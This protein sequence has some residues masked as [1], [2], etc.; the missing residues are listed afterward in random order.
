[1]SNDSHNFYERGRYKMIFTDERVLGR[2]L[3]VVENAI[4]EDELV[5]NEWQTKE[6][7]YKSPGEYEDSG[8]WELINLG[9]RWTCSDG[10][11]RW[12]YRIVEV[13]EKFAGKN[14]VLDLEFGGEGLVKING[15][16]QS[17]LTSYLD[18]NEATRTRVVL[19]HVPAAGEKFEVEVEAGLNYMEF[20]HY[21]NQGW[22]SIEY[23]FR[24]AT[25]AAVDYE[26]EQYYFDI[27]TAFDAMLA[28]KSPIQKLTTA[29]VKLPF[30]MTRILESFTKDSYIH[31]KLQDAVLHSLTR[32]DADFGRDAVAKSVP[33]ASEIL[34][35]K[36]SEI[37]H[38]PHAL[39][40]FVGQAHIDTAWL[41]PIKETV[42]KCG[43]TMA[44]VLDLMDR[45]ED[46]I[47]SFSQPQLFEYTKKYYP[48]LYDRIKEKVESGQFELVGNTWVEMDTNVPSG[49]SLV[50]QLLYGRAFFQSEFGKSSRVFWMPDVFGYSWALPQI[51]KRSGMDYFF[52]SKLIGNDTN[53]FPHSLF[54]WQ[55]ID[56]TQLLSYVQRLN[57]N[58]KYTPETVE[59]IYN[60]F[61]QKHLTDDLLMTF[62]YGDGGGGPNYQ[63]LETSHRL[64]SFPGLQKTELNT[65]VS[66]FDSV[67]S[68]ADKLPVWNNEMYYEFHR[69]TYTSQARTKKHNREAE[70]GMRQAEML[71]AIAKDRYETDYPYEDILEAYRLILTNQFHD[72]IPGSSIQSVYVDCEKDYK[73]IFSIIRKIEA[74]SI[75][76]LSSISESNCVTVFNS[77]SWDRVDYVRVPLADNLNKLSVVDKDGNHVPSVY[78][79][80]H[81]EFE[82]WAPALGSAAYQLVENAPA[83]VKAISVSKDK[84]ENDFYEILLDEN[85]NLTSIYDKTSNCEV[86]EQGKISNQLLIFEDKP[87]CETAWNIDL[88]Y[89]NKYWDLVEGTVQVI[90]QS[91][92]KGVVRVTKKFNL[93]T[94]I[95]DIV[96]YRSIPRID[97]RTRVD[98]NETEKML[99][100]AFHVNV[101]SSKAVYEIQ[102]GAIERP[103]HWNTSYDK[104][105][106]E[107]CGHK[108]A[109]LSEGGYGVSLLNDSK[110]GYDIKDNCM[111]ITLLRAPTDPDPDA[112]KGMQ[113]MCYS[114]MPHAGDYRKGMTV[115]AGYELNVPM[116]SIIGRSMNDDSSFANISRSNVIIDTIKCAEDGRGLIMRVYESN[117]TR[118]NTSINLS[119]HAKEVFECNLMEEDERLV[120]THSDSFEF[121]VK[122]FEI[123]TFRVIR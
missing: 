59:T 93:S 13:P 23:Q 105:K 80:D 107:V 108:W 3:K 91:P 88:E 62:G 48:E 40:K 43:K 94:I 72:I 1:M 42:R 73:H 9:E 115:N 95:Q 8:Q 55:G 65:S 79:D 5:L 51:I 32:I 86:L 20:A 7:F 33:S 112:D 64:K 75:N 58:G 111:R 100:A 102:F 56:G 92:I 6:G 44:N 25:L 99:K 85:G 122:P 81:V 34:N 36:L 117:G 116:T 30:E 18:E 52:T 69:G 106:F 101:L 103:T 22:T 67:N 2:K 119:G 10:T 118:G 83:E 16:I 120:Y 70:L 41:W 39:I 114:L 26:V 90:E 19:P 45:Y 35:E 123:K 61:D 15:A 68:I 53:H 97:F 63:M 54:M 77:L 50:R 57:Y 78:K 60:R 74:D 24:K 37:Q 87:Y 29:N 89:Q 82:A 12:F 38:S 110:Y 66:F 21:R 11:T 14:V 109:D 113:E 49:E 76:N 28:L 17:A 104:A 47:F 96:I 84:M 98:W 4:Y 46:F 27:K 71:A 121:F 31:K